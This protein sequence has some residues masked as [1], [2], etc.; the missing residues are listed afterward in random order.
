[1]RSLA[2][3]LPRTL[4][5]TAPVPRGKRLASHKLFP[6][7]RQDVCREAP[8][9]QHLAPGLQMMLKLDEYPEY[10]LW[11][12]PDFDEDALAA[13][14]PYVPRDGICID[15]GANVGHWSL[16]FSHFVGPGG[17]VY[18]FE[19]FPPFFRRLQH[20]ITLNKV[21]NVT[22][23]QRA[24]GNRVGTIDFDGA[25]CHFAT[26]THSPSESRIQISSDTLSDFIEANGLSRLDFLK[27]DIQGAELL[28]LQGMERHFR[29][30]WRPA[31]CLELCEVL[32]QR[33]GYSTRD[34]K[35]YMA[36]WGYTG[37]LLHRGHLLTLERNSTHELIDALFLPS[38]ARPVLDVAPS[39]SS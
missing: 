14:R 36:D 19:P 8:V 20:N 17:H 29:K 37:W 33:L 38:S 15:A 30:G 5:N 2:A 21:K 27:M 34:V 6:L 10:M 28:A 24:L 39:N 16:V 22:T 1:M 13:C 26:N 4:I 18:A 32:C 31:F 12:L 9:S 25:R 35:K 23:V 7:L 11:I 3:T